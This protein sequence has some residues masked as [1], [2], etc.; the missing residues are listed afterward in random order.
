MYTPLCTIRALGIVRRLPDVTAGV[1]S[2]GTGVPLR[3][4]VMVL[5]GTGSEGEHV[6]VKDCPIRTAVRTGRTVMMG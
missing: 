6:R 3:S 5:P 1:S 4:Q 2:V